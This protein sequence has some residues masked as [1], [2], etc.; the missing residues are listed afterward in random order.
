M[1]L[2]VNFN[3]KPGTTE[4]RDVA[5]GMMVHLSGQPIRDYGFEFFRGNNNEQAYFAPVYFAFTDQAKRDAAMKKWNEW[6]E[7]QSKK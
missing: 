4:V 2:N 5:L 3:N 6:K 1:L 7:K